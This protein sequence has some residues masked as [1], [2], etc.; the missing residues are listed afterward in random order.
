MTAVA[1]SAPGMIPLNVA[2][3]EAA[4]TAPHAWFQSAESAPSSRP[5]KHRS[6]Q[7]GATVYK[8]VTL[9]DIPRSSLAAADRSGPGTITLHM[10]GT[11]AAIPACVQSAESL[12]PAIGVFSR[13]PS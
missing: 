12:Y 3:K 9:R 8:R 13:V 6:A 4:I 11:E 5:R 2:G 7:T 10:T 1:R